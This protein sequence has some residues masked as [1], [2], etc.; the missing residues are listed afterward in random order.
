MSGP[1]P[2]QRTKDALLG[3]GERVKEGK[4][5]RFKCRKRADRRAL[6]G[7][8]KTTP[9]NWG[10]GG[11]GRGGGGGGGRGKTCFQPFYVA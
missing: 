2:Y 9:L 11:G 6:F 8:K 3:V 5:R 1:D 7:K 10:G 4:F